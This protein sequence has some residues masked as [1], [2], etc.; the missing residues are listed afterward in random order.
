M[1]ERKKTETENAEENVR[2]IMRGG[3]GNS[4]HEP[5]A[6]YGRK[7]RRKEVERERIEP[8]RVQQGQGSGRKS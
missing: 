7:E 8:A 5:K 6:S 4:R 2:E 1:E 3:N